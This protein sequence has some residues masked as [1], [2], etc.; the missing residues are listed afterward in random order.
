MSFDYPSMQSWQEELYKDL[1]R[2]PE[3]S[4]EEVRTNGVISRE[5]TSFGYEVQEIGGGI[6]GVLQNNAANDAGPVVLFRADTDALPV[7]EDTGLDYASEVPGVMHA[8]G[9]D[10]HI[11]CG[12]GAARWLAEN[13]D[14]WSGTYIALFQP[15]EEIAGGARAMVEDGLVAKVPRPDVALAQHVMP[16]KLGQLQTVAGASM[17]QAASLRVVIYG[18]GSHGSMPHLSIDPVVLAASIVL[19]LQTIVARE[20][21]PGEFGVV[22]VGAIQAGAKSNVIPDRAELL[23]NVRTYSN[24]THEKILSAI[25]RIV[26]G[27]CAVAGSPRSP[28]IEIYDEFPLT[29]NDAVVTE[30]VTQ[31]FEQ[32]FGAEQVV[33]QKKSTGSEDFS[34]IP[35]AWNTP[36]LYWHLGGFVPGTEVAN[37][38][39]RFAPVMQPTLRIGTEAILVAALE[40][41]RKVTDN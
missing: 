4:F 23:L 20:L 11:S 3:L 22:T 6:V 2:H 38:N 7:S 19:R 31:A 26:E 17:S 29:D 18:K 1:H 21:A 24:E 30:R 12:L 14:S 13:R 39:P 35:N 27:E 15:A 28:E 41:F 25:R 8:C 36:Y 10:L 32:Y 5:L 9:H 33:E 16:A 37:H 34:F 40:F